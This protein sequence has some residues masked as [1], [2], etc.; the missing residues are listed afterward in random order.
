MIRIRKNPGIF[1]KDN[2]KFEFEKFKEYVEEVLLKEVITVQNIPYATLNKLITYLDDSQII[3]EKSKINTNTV[4]LILN[5]VNESY[6]KFKTFTLSML[7]FD[8]ITLFDKTY[9]YLPLFPKKSFEDFVIEETNIYKVIKK[10]YPLFINTFAEL[11][12]Q[13]NLVSS[14][15]LV[16]VKAIL[17]NKFEKILRKN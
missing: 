10:I 9:V 6:G 3:I 7:I 2:S 16:E 13:K 5:Y 11:C 8:S 17:K 14:S 4:Y 15:D 1:I 12:K